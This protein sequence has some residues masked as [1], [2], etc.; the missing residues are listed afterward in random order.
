MKSPLS[1]GDDRQRPLDAVVDRREQ[2]RPEL[3]HERPLGRL[4]DLTDLQARR[5][6]VDLDRGRVALE[7]DDLTHEALVRP[8]GRCRTCVAP[9]MPS[10]MTTGPVIFAI[11]PTIMS[12]PPQRDVE[13]DGAPDQ[14]AI[15]TRGGPRRPRAARGSA[16][17]RRSADRCESI[18][19][20]RRSSIAAIMR[21]LT[22]MMPLASSSTSEASVWRACSATLDLDH[23]HARQPEA[24]CRVRVG[25]D[26]ELIHG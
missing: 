4:D 10:A 2:P 21:S 13:S 9:V 18:L 25:E 20:W 3:D 11:V 1:C 5:V 12:S 16:A 8:P 14:R 24:V 23:V 15:G 17:R 26:D 6:L 7:P 22:A 19:R